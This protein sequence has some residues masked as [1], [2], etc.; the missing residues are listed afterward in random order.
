MTLS[1][2]ENTFSECYELMLDGE[3]P[4]LNPSAGSSVGNTGPDDFNPISIPPSGELFLNPVAPAEVT[5]FYLRVGK[6]CSEGGDL[7][8]VVT[9]Y[10]GMAQEEMVIMHHTL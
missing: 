10:N 5:E 8:I 6:T 3:Q 1:P 7:K 9:Y 2:F 4:L